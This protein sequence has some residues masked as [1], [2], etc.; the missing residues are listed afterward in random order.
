MAVVMIIPMINIL[1]ALVNPH[2]AYSFLCS[3]IQFD[4]ISCVEITL[5]TILT[6]L[7]TKLFIA[8][9]LVVFRM[10]PKS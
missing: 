4:I 5:V 1:G 6:D 9:R 2:P 7:I 8:L 10:L 3:N